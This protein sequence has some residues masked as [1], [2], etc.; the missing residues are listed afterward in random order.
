MK[1]GVFGTGMVGEAIGSKLVSL[2]HDVKM[3]SRTSGNDKAVAWAKKAGSLAS[4]GSFAEAAA[5]GEM[6]FNCTRGDVSLAVLESAG[7]ASLRGKILV[8]LANPLDFSKGMPPSLF[9]SNTDSLGEQIQRA[10]P[11]LKVVKT[12]NTINAALMV[13]PSRIKGEHSLLMSGN[14][15]EAKAA[16]RGL[17]TEGFGWKDIVDLGD[18]STARGTES[19]LLL[20]L[21]LWGALKTPDFNIKVVR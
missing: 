16:V 10:F 11:E 12:L 5:H 18:I 21:R 1:I 20:W 13:D 3:G 17:L 6:L 2:G 8:D 7:A 19:Y 9:V 4:E 15:P 14:D